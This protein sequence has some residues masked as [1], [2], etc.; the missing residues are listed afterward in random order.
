MMNLLPKQFR[1]FYIQ[2]FHQTKRKA[3]RRGVNMSP[4]R[5]W[6]FDLG[7]SNLFGFFRSEDLKR[8]P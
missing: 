4:F 8:C 1:L 3:L 6:S 2:V 7:L 5:D